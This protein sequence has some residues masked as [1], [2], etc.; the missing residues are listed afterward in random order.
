MVAADHIQVSRQ[1][2]LFKHHGIDLGDGTVAHYLEG[3]EILRS[4]IEDFCCGQL[5]N[6]VKHENADPKKITLHRAMSRIGE[7]SYNLLFNNCEHFANWCKI[8]V[9]RS[10]QIEE[11]LTKSSFSSLMIGQVFPAALL[12]G[13]NILIKEGLKDDQARMKAVKILER[14]KNLRKKLVIKLEQSIE[15]LDNWH[16]SSQQNSTDRQK[17]DLPKKLLLKGHNIADKLTILENLEHQISELIETSPIN[18]VY[19]INK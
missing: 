4:T 10:V 5:I 17:K 2:G 1:H 18:S 9:H 8:G 14:I 11:F 6:V 7:Q 19:D 16:T 13:L 12:S 15:K 3:K